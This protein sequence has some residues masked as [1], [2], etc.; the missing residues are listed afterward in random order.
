MIAT[1]IN[2]LLMSYTIKTRLLH[3]MRKEVIYTDVLP[4]AMRSI[5]EQQTA[6]NSAITHMM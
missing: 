6:A 3:I 2:I 5:V 4:C 1:H